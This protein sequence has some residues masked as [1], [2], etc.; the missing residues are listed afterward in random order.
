MLFYDFESSYQLVGFPG[1]SVGKESTCNRGGKGD[2]DSIRGLG[3]FFEGGKWQPTPAVLPEKSH[4]QSS[5]EG[6][7]PWDCKELD[8]TERLRAHQNMWCVFLLVDV[9]VI[10]FI[11]FLKVFGFF[12]LAESWI[13]SW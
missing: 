13:Y 9:S 11:P 10:F 12:P 8:M 7:S 4:G 6:Y 5:L 1:G 2:M 3:R